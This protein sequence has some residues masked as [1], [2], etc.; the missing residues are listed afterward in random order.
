MRQLRLFSSLILLFTLGCN[1]SSRPGD[2]GAQQG[3]DGAPETGSDSP[4]GDTA[5][6]GDSETNSSGS[7]ETSGGSSGEQEDE[8]TGVDEG[9]TGSGGETQTSAESDTSD[10]DDGGA[11][12]Y[13]D[14]AS[15]LNSNAGTPDAPL[16]TIQEALDRASMTSG[17]TIRVAAGD[18]VSNFSDEDGILIH[19]GVS[20]LGGFA[21]DWSTRAPLTFVTRITGGSS[22][23]TN[24]VVRIEGGNRDDTVID[25]V[26]IE[27]SARD[28]TGIEIDGA[29]TVSNVQI[30][31]HLPNHAS[32]SSRGVVVH[33]GSPRITRSEIVAIS[34]AGASG[35]SIH[36]G[37]A[38]IDSN[39]IV[40][41]CSGVNSNCG[42][43]GVYIGSQEPAS[44]FANNI[45]GA[46]FPSSAVSVLVGDDV[47]II[48]N[49]LRNGG[50]GPHPNHTNR[51]LTLGDPDGHPTLRNN[52]L[53]GSYI[54]D[55]PGL[56]PPLT[57]IAAL[58]DHFASASE[59][60][61]AEA[62]FAPNAYEFGLDPTA[63]VDCE[64]ARGGLDLG[65]DFAVDRHGQPRTE[66]WTIGAV[67]RDDACY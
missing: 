49:I 37:E 44:V 3:S 43:T 48:G 8:T 53:V 19:E 12:F 60:V 50:A 55:P 10:D 38:V 26:R 67:E 42:G 58:H 7:G 30:W 40:A 14:E 1:S 23:D 24:V 59:N 34:R 66:P 57:T 33:G 25:G 39:T 62:E 9:S 4:K 22:P 18:Y 63:P 15:G 41:H 32:S 56:A 65:P 11:N 51:I 52:L 54:Y 31:V 17:A 64:I 2:G 13:V 21:P 6:T 45:S 28:A 36:A 29:P 27:P 47:E 46:G 35:V 16:R 5:T 61:R 20:I